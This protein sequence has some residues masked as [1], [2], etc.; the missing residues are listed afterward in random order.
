MYCTYPS[1]DESSN[2][3][4]A[5]LSFSRPRSSVHSCIMPPAGP[6]PGPS[7]RPSSTPPALQLSRYRANQSQPGDTRTDHEAAKRRPRAKHEPCPARPRPKPSH[8]SALGLQRMPAHELEG[9]L[10]LGH[11]LYTDG[12]PRQDGMLRAVTAANNRTHSVLARITWRPHNT[13]RQIQD[14]PAS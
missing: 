13:T 7:S 11:H 8:G 2:I 10:P 14:S 5:P 4:F 6:F 3:D 9:M 12:T 1:S